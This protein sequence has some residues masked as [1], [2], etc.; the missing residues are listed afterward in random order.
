MNNHKGIITYISIGAMMLGVMQFA[1]FVKGEVRLLRD[2]NDIQPESTM[3]RLL[4]SHKF[5]PIDYR[6][7]HICNLMTAALI[8]N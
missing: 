1:V 2:M 4:L 3:L 5:V 6:N 8:R 7:I